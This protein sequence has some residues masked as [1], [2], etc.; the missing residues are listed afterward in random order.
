MWIYER[1]NE[2]LQEYGW[3]DERGEKEEIGWSNT[4]EFKR[5]KKSISIKHKKNEWINLRLIIGLR[6][7]NFN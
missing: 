2:R 6:N 4:F 3:S 5:L 1:D 7:I